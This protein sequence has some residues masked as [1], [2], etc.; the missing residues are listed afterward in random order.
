MPVV[1][2][3]GNF[4]YILAVVALFLFFNSSKTR[5]VAIVIGI[6]IL[7]S[8][9]T[10]NQLKHLVERPRPCKELLDIHLLGGCSN[11]FSFPSNHSANM[12]AS[13]LILSWKYRKLTA[14]FFLAAVTVA[15][16]RVYIGVHYPFD[17]MGGA[18]I[19]LVSGALALSFEHWYLPRISP[20]LERYTWKRCNE[21]GT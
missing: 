3:F 17:V 4:K 11:S 8:D 20:L 1:T 9:Q 13:A 6:A 12:F 18:L 21:S 16:S 14:L 5:A 7:L 15:F 19:G 10:G 2:S